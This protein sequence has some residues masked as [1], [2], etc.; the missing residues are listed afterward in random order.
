MK[1]DEYYEFQQSY[2]YEI[3]IDE[4]EPVFGSVE[5]S[6]SIEWDESRSAY[7]ITRT[8]NDLASNFSDT[9]EGPKDEEFDADLMA[10]LEKP[11]DRLERSS[12]AA[13]ALTALRSNTRKHERRHS[14]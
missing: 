4:A 2:D 14:R 12:L 11:G 5:W 8:W 9:G 6:A 7:E 13:L 3:E 1:R 10:Y